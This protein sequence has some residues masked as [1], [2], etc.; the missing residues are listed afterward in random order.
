VAIIVLY[1]AAGTAP[2]RPIAT[3]EVIRPTR[4]N[5]D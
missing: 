4:M 3:H 1:I 2:C 5:A